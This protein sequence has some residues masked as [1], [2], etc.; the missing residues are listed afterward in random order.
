MVFQSC[1]AARAEL[2]RGIVGLR[3]LEFLGGGG[4]SVM[5]EFDPLETRGPFENLQVAFMTIP[6]NTCPR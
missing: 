1:L 6:V 4:L 5:D 2:D 3:D